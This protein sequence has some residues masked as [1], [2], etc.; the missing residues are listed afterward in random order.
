[1]NSLSV[2]ALSVEVAGRA[3][4]KDVSFALQPGELFALIGPNGAGKSTVLK[5]L[6][7]LIPHTGLVALQGE[8]LAH[9]PPSE[10]AVRL[11]FLAQGDQVVWPLRVRDFVELGRLPHQQGWSQRLSATDV[12]AVDTALSAMQLQA[13]QHRHLNE[14]S[15]GERARVRLARALAVQAQVLLADEPV[16]ALDPYHQLRV[17]E[18]LRAQCDAGRSVI[19]VLH[20]LTLASRFCDRV[21]LLHGGQGVACGAPRHVLTPGNLQRVYQLKAMHGEHERQGYVVPW[22][23][24]PCA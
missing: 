18:L 9:L 22:S 6:A 23:C 11:S 17:M 15:G 13:F 4:V 24:R 2:E 8:R 12:S 1:M 19:V 10:R 16:A 21:L 5:A 3:C 7:Q 20:D 14:L